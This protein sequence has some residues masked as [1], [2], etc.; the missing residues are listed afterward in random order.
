MCHEKT[1]PFIHGPHFSSSLGVPL[2]QKPA[3]FYK[4]LPTFYDSD[5]LRVDLS[6]MNPSK[7]CV[8]YGVAGVGLHSG[9]SRGNI[10]LQMEGEQ[11]R[12]VPPLLGRKLI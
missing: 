1:C 5:L 11:A 10:P 6:N 12:Y 7:G 3:F 2:T 9:K 8:V 4:F